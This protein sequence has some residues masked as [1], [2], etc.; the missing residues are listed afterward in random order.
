MINALKQIIHMKAALWVN[1]FC[2]YFKRLWLIGKWMPDS[3]Y[4][5]YGVKRVFSVI[6]LI[7]RQLIDLCGKP[8][9]LLTFVGFPLLMM[10][11][12]HPK[13]T[14]LPAMVQILF[15]LNCVIGSFGESQIFSVTREKITCIK[16][17][18][19]DARTYTQAFLAF[20][21][22]P[23][24]L[25]YLPW[26]LIAARLA[27][28]TL[29]QG[30]FVWLMLLSFRMM[31]E[32]FH[33]LVFERT[34]T[35]IHRNMLYSWVVIGVG[36]A[37]AY[38]PAAL[39][40]ELPLAAMLIHPVCVAAYTLAG[41][42]SLWYIHIGYSGYATK[43][44]RS[45]DQNFLLSSL[46]KA[47]SGTTAGFKEVEMKETDTLVS[48]AA[49]ARFQKLKGYAYLNAIFFARHRRQLLKPVYYRLM[50]AAVLFA[51]AVVFL[52]ANREAAIRLSKNLTVML[53]FFVYIMYFM[54]VADKASKA[55]FYNCDKDMLRYAY[56]RQPQTIL[57][58]FQIRLLRVSLY[59]F[60]IAGAVCLAAAGFCLLCGGSIFTMDLLLFSVTILLL[61]LLFTAHHLCLYYIFQP[62]SEN[63]QVKN[64]FYSAINFGMYFLCLLCLQIEAGGFTFTTGTLVFTIL[65]IAAA[66]AFVYYRAPKSFRI[67]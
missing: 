59:D 3:I 19:M 21:Y 4:S 39:G 31:G 48:E 53:P 55:M 10:S 8:L 46:L 30:F 57:K 1:S 67:K 25:Y 49:K 23:F 27:G 40:W 17:L 63:L 38:L 7:I 13:E 36:L 11:D 58:N 33:L 50:A 6:A 28:G 34:G 32:A 14:I 60:A 64:P 47:S 44:R 43:L 65:Y 37:G 41:I 45:I 52:I 16:Y 22:V 54:T 42:I 12:S 35:V 26:L 15:F 24:F 29:L 62:Y 2:Y 9:Y 18:H 61:S 56:Y 51:A 5:L 20:K 66:L